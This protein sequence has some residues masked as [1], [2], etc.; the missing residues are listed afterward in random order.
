MELIF[1]EAKIDVEEENENLEDKLPKFK[2]VNATSCNDV[3]VVSS[4]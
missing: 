2:Q 4:E 1:L 3:S